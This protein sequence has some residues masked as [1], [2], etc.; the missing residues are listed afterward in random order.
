MAAQRRVVLPESVRKHAIPTYGGYLV[1]CKTKRD[2]NFACLEI[3]KKQA[4]E[5]GMANVGDVGSHVDLTGPG[6][7]M[8]YVIGQF[9]GGG[10]PALLHELS[11]VAFHVME[12]V[13]IPINKPGQETYTYLFDSLVLLAMQRAAKPRPLG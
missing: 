12:H 3:N 1:I 9:S 6:G 11:H 5:A 7:V 4:I 13:G 10:L 2:Y 8:Y